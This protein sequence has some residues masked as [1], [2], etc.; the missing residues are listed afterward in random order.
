VELALRE[1][2]GDAGDITSECFVDAELPGHGRIVAREP[3]M[4]V[5]GLSLV[6]AVFGALDPDVEV[7]PSV[8]DGAEV[9]ADET[10]AVV[11]GRFRS[12][13][14]G[15]RTA[16]NF[17]QRLSGIATLTRRFVR[18]AGADGPGILDTRKTT[19]GWRAL[20]K[21]AVRHGGGTNHRMGLHDAFMVKDNHLLAVPGP[22]ELGRLIG[23]ARARYPGVRVQLEADTLAQLEAFLALEGVDSVLLDNMS[24]EELRSA[25]AMRDRAKPHVALEASGG[26]TLDAI[27][28]LAGSGVDFISVGALTHSAR[29]VDLALDLAPARPDGKP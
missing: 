7:L 23:E 19:P 9:G 26:V 5:S 10:V 6:R 17:L 15:E 28:E 29:A 25:V 4:V 14:T 13:L 12:L 8:E 24:A 22:G 18:A 2:L 11:R 27:A 21:E 16:L 20:E 1:D 3:R